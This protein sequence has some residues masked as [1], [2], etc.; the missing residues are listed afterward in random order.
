MGGGC[1]LKRENSN[2]DFK[3]TDLS[4]DS[5]QYLFKK[6][7]LI[8]DADCIPLRDM[9]FFNDD[10]IIFSTSSYIHEPYFR[11]MW[12][13]N[14]GFNEN[15]LDSNK[16]FVSEHMMI[17]SSVMCAL[18]D[19]IEARFK[20]PFWEAILNAIY[21]RDL[22]FS[23]FSE[24]ETYGHFYIN[25]KNFMLTQRAHNRFAKR[26]MSGILDD[27]MLLWAGRD[28]EIICFELWIKSSKIAKL[29]RFK[30][31][32]AIFSAKFLMKLDKKLSKKFKAFR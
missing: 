26:I 12:Q 16:S 20:K 19:T 27:E 8:W 10:K 6:F 32:R 3:K 7:Y 22:A 13:L 28:Y 2:L 24:F 29:S 14:L 21:P 9:E 4:V 31:I 15:L 17:D 11:T 25:L 1:S 18:L 5:N 23:G 30:F